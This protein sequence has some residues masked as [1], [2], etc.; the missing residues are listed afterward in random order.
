MLEEDEKEEQQANQQHILILTYQ[1]CLIASSNNT[2]FMT[3]LV[4][5]YSS[6]VEF[7]VLRNVSI[8][9]T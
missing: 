4:S 9:R 8:E 1:Q 5:L 7:N 6:N 2:K 3:A